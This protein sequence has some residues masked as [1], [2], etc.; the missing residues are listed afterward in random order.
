M[1]AVVLFSSCEKKAPAPLTKAQIQHRID[2]ITRERIE[3][4]TERA[5]IDLEYRI[6]IEVKVKADSIVR[7]MQKTD[8]AAQPA[9][10]QP[11]QR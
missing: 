3:D 6:K 5:R 2:S 4:V 11:E 7:A 8:A 10:P 9:S 1:V